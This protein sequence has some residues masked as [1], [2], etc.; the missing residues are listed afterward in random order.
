[1]AALRA[2]PVT[3]RTA[4]DR[5]YQLEVP[6]TLSGSGTRDVPTEFRRVQ[7]WAGYVCGDVHMMV[8]VN[9]FMRGRQSLDETVAHDETFF[10]IDAAARDVDVAGSAR[11]VRLEGTTRVLGPAGCER[12]LMVVAEADEVIALTLRAA[13]RDDVAAVMDR[14]AQSFQLANDPT[15]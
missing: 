9:C 6:D 10:R 2:T 11:A 13:D 15:Q 4:R 12:V 1:M 8:S 14:I 3:W 5:G 7:T